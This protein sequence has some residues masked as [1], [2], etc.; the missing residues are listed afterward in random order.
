[1]S[2]STRPIDGERLSTQAEAGVLSG[3]PPGRRRRIANRRELSKRESFLWGL[4]GIVVLI[5]V[6][7]LLASLGMINGLA[8]S[9]PSQVVSSAKQL[10]SDGTLGPKVLSSAGLFG[11]GFGLSVLVGLIVGT[12]LG[13]YTRLNAF[14]DPWVSLLYATPRLALI[15]LVV[16]WVGVGFE[17]RVLVVF[18][19]AVFPII[20]NVA[21][22]VS[23]VDRDHL[24]LARS[25]LATNRDVLTTIALP[26]AIPAIVSGIRQGMI[27]SLIGVV[28]AEYFI[29]ST[30]VGGLI[31]QAGL[32][33]QTA[34][35]F[36]GALIFA[37]AALLLTVLLQLLERRLD[38]WRTTT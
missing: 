31:F 32:T 20:I 34:Q 36:V 4:A 30:G 7:Q 9:S 24:R 13:W 35:A 3:T 6:W 27:L 2:S 22:G 5:G 26:G 11:V 17:A 19:V 16:V 25:F 33:L 1:M 10:I 14:L 37:L 21:S 23:S 8:G 38:R 29:G 15:P 28:V 18:T 12:L